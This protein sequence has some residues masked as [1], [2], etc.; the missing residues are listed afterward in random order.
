[1]HQHFALFDT[2]TVA[3][4]VAVGLP[5]GR[6][7]AEI[8]EEVRTLGEK[9][10][11]EVDPAAV[12]YELSMGERQRVEIIRALMTS[13]KLLIRPCSFLKPSKNSS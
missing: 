1:M 9:Y 4:N 11:L 8:S 5:P 2:L 12:V 7:T 6:S 3:E 10:G 13:P